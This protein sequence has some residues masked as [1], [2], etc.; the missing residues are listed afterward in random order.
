MEHSGK[1]EK[2]CLSFFFLIPLFFKDFYIRVI[3]IGDWGWRYTAVSFKIFFQ[4]KIEVGDVLDEMCGECLKGVG[5]SGVSF[6]DNRKGAKLIFTLFTKTKIK[7]NQTGLN[8]KHLQT[9]DEIP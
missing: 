3:K 5:K 4:R 8:W 1:G 2:C 9:T 6:Y 7:K